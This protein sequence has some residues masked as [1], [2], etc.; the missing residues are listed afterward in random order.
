MKMRN[1][2]IISI[3]IIAFIGIGCVGKNIQQ[4]DNGI[5]P[6]TTVESPRTVSGPAAPEINNGPIE[7]TEN[8][9]STTDIN[10]GPTEKTEDNTTVETTTVDNLSTNDTSVTEIFNIGEEKKMLDR[11]IKLIDITDYDNNTVVLTIDGVE[12]QYSSE[13]SSIQAGNIEVFDIITS[14]D[15]KTA[16]VTIDYIK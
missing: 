1:V 16:E 10:N 7:K 11:N 6:A 4:T 9:S 14:A 5:S 2:Y 3:L 8:N 12:Y 15:D 13:N